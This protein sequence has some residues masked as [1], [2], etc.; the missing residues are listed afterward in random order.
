M[1]FL[2]WLKINYNDIITLSKKIDKENGEEV[3]HFTIDKF[4]IGDL[5]LLDSLTDDNKL[6]YMSRTLSLQSKSKSSQF[7]R[8]VKRFTIITDDVILPQ[9]EEGVEELE[10]REAQLDFIEKE[11]N[12]IN[13][14]SSLLFRRYC[15][16][17]YSAQ[18]LADRLVIPLSTVQYHLRKVK[19]HIRNKWDKQKH[20]YI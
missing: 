9:V 19:T 20:L 1:T 3:L 14:F 5:E 18:K 2:N 13:W 6:R 10:Y 8:E 12:N 15:E 11:L 7:Y 4:L 17:N 16:T